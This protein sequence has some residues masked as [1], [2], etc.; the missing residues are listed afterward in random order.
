M[1]HDS[2][3]PW[4]LVPLGGEGEETT[5]PKSI[6]HRY[7]ASMPSRYQ[8]QIYRH[9]KAH[10]EKQVQPPVRT[11]DTGTH[12]Y[13]ATMSEDD[14]DNHVHFKMCAGVSTAFMKPVGVYMCVCFYLFNLFL[15]VSNDRKMKW[16]CT[17]R[18]RQARGDLTHFL[19]LRRICRAKKKNGDIWEETE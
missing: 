15:K 12:I 19:C 9:N 17:Y 10:F 8:R 7:R 6:N 16:W 14:F 5:A 3:C 11:L 4:A 2:S 18:C 13:A 1:W